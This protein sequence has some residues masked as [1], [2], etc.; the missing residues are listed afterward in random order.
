MDLTSCALIGLAAVVVSLMYFKNWNPWIPITKVSTRRLDQLVKQADDVVNDSFYLPTDAADCAGYA[1][2]FARRAAELF[3]I[4]MLGDS[5]LYANL[6]SA[7]LFWVATFKRESVAESLDALDLTRKVNG[8][9]RLIKDDNIET[10]QFLFQNLDDEDSHP[11]LK[12]IAVFARKVVQKQQSE[13]EAW[14]AL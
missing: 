12:R 10:A 8:G 7:V 3:S 14:S 1:G 4:G 5:V 2:D 13:K 9:L 6:A 11:N